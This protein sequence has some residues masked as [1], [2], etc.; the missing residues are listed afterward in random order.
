MQVH[1]TIDITQNA[2]VLVCSESIP[3]RKSHNRSTN[4]FIIPTLFWWPFKF[5]ENDQNAGD[6]WQRFNK[7]AGGEIVHKNIK[8]L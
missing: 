1:L 7:N 5:S 2:Q 3:E 6:D 8:T 4:R